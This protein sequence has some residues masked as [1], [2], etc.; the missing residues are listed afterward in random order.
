[1]DDKITII[2]GPPP[3]F[4]QV[5]DGWAMGLNESPSVLIPALT[6]LRTFNGHA[7]VERCHRAWNSK[8]PIHLHYR[9]DM[10]LEETAPILAARNVETPDGHV[11]LLWVYLDS[12]HVEYEFDGDDDDDE[13]AED[14]F[15][16]GPGA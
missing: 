4:E 12:E 15:M 7:L 9:N 1:M 6:R 10:G 11:L 16:D 5:N 2:E 14:D 13:G 3:I 8:E